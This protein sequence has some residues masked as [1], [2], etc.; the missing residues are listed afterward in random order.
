MADITI[1]TT[2]TRVVVTELSEQVTRIVVSNDQPVKIITASTQGPPGRDGEA[3][4]AGARIYSEQLIGSIDGSN[5]L[6]STTYPYLEIIELSINGLG[7]ENFTPTNT[8]ALTLVDT[9]LVGDILKV[10]YT[11]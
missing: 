9:P 4:A 11:Y 1:N 10:I 8:T 5:K 3:G 7:G 2:E 6:F